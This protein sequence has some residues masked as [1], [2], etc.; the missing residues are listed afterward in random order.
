MTSLYIGISQC[1]RAFYLALPFQN[2]LKYHESDFKSFNGNYF[3]TLYINVVRLTP[4]TP[5]FKFS[6]VRLAAS[7]LYTAG[8]VLRFY[9]AIITQVC[10]IYLL[11][12]VTAMPRG[13]HAR[14]CHD[15]LVS[16]NILTAAHFRYNLYVCRPIAYRVRRVIYQQFQHWLKT[17]LSRERKH[18]R[19]CQRSCG[20]CCV[21]TGDGHCSC[22]GCMTRVIKNTC[23]TQCRKTGTV[24]HHWK[25]TLN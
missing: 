18:I 19:S 8:S 9:G 21:T 6:D 5:E 4:V 3:S 17:W 16:V 1:I 24:A 14:L 23:N 15:F 12:D 25:F 11:W 22:R 20:S 10:F 7:P 13:L 2:G